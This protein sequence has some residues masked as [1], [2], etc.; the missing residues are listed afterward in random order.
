LAA[1]DRFKELAESDEYEDADGKPKTEQRDLPEFHIPEK[2][3]LA[4]EANYKKQA[5]ALSQAR[6]QASSTWRA[7]QATQD[8]EVRAVLG[9][10]VRNLGVTRGDSVLAA[11]VNTAT[12]TPALVLV[13]PGM[14]VSIKVMVSE[15]DVVKIAEGQ[16]VTV[17]L[18]AV[19]NR[20]F[21]GRVD[22]VDT[23]TVPAGGVVEYGVYVLLEGPEDIIRAGMT[24]DVNIKV[25][26]KKDVLVVPSSA[27]KPHEGGRAVRMLGDN[28]EIEFVKVSTGSRGDGI[29]EIVDGVSEGEEIIVALGNEQVDR[30]GMSFF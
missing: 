14:G 12:T 9:G 7:Y 11:N 2:E 21:R 20:E 6:A 28:G 10:E 15:S 24:A 26:E 1:W 5:T 19:A 4:A 13:S 29:V 27:V 16:E 30:K 23:L 22:R 3:W 18:D 8:S 25:A 17:E